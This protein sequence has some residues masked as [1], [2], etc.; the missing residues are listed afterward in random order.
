MIRLIIETCP[1]LLAARQE[2]AEKAYVLAQRPNCKKKKKE[3]KREKRS[4]ALWHFFMDFMF[5]MDFNL[6]GFHVLDN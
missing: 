5:F 4:K 2:L 6:Y 3:R 1:N